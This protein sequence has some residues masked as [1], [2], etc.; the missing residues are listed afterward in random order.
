MWKGVAL[1]KR[2]YRALHV[3]SSIDHMG[4]ALKRWAAGPRMCWE[5]AGG[6]ALRGAPRPIRC[7]FLALGGDP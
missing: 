2:G 6:V 7:R 4:A 1:S 5:G 3:G